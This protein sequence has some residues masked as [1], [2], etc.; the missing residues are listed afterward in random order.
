MNYIW[1]GMLGVGVFFA[2][3]NHRL[4]EFTEGLMTSCTKAVYFVIGLMGIMAVW[5]GIMNIAKET[6]LIDLVA[7]KVKPLMRF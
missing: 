5:S 4:S 2:I 3:I 1:A 6:G 7:K